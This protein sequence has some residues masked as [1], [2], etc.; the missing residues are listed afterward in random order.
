MAF[1]LS[2]EDSEEAGV[3]DR[4]DEEKKNERTLVC[5][6]VSLTVRG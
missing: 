5:G 3:L 1:S 4:M 6:A 2:R